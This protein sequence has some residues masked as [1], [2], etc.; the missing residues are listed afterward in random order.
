MNPVNGLA[1]GRIAIGVAAL[2]SPALGAKL[3][4]VDLARNQQLPYMMRLFASREIAL[5][6]MTLVAKGTA[7]RKLVGLGMA[8]DGSDAFASYDAMRSGAISQT[9]GVFLT[10]P[11]IG[12]V[13]TGAI[14][15]ATER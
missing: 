10:G 5:G 1:L 6:A 14:G 7:R 2:A 9:T 11:A 12:A 4:R 3:F 13:V 8:I 15:L